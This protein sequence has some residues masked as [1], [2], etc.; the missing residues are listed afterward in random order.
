MQDEPAVLS[1]VWDLMRGG[2]EGQ[3]ARVAMELAGRRCR[4]HV[5]V[6]RRSGFFLDAVEKTCG[7]VQTLNIRR[8]LSLATER[9]IRKLA[10]WIREENIQL[11]HAWDADSVLFGRRIAV[12]AD[13]PLI[14][15]HR[16][17]GEIYP[18]WKLKGMA[19]ADRHAA[20]VIA[21]AR[22]IAAKAIPSDVPD[23]RVEVIP[24]ILDLEEFD[25]LAKEASPWQ[26]PDDG[27]SVIACVGRLDPE[28]DVGSL[29]RAHASMNA[30]KRPWVLIAG[31]GQER[32]GLESLAAEHVVFLGE[33]HDIPAL[34]QQA[35]LGVLCPNRNEGLSNS[36]LEMMAASLPCVVTDCGG[37]SELVKDGVNGR[38]VPV[39][40]SVAL[41]SAI[42][43]LLSLP[44]ACET[45]GR[46]SR[47]IIEQNHLPEAVAD[48]FAAC[49]RR[50]ARRDLAS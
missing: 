7:P 21:N 27:R 45:M 47:H 20:L 16:D 40:D 37:N 11:L 36:V 35:D 38:V 41:A 34:L 48:Q 50:A 32:Q 4:H 29:L 13:I 25:L 19:N 42:R 28:K 5:G 22:A 44:N 10:H 43:E 3:C 49:Y 2:T 15:S 24:N 1:L 8:R 46:V 14:T 33:V 30:A 6:F 18:V 31:D 26:R 9:E 17:M 39:G 12:R 23:D